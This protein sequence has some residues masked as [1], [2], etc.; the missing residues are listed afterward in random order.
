ML[1]VVYT[2]ESKYS[3]ELRVRNSIIYRQL[4]ILYLYF[5]VFKMLNSI[6]DWFELTKTEVLYYW[7]SHSLSFPVICAFGRMYVR[8]TRY[9]VWCSVKSTIIREEQVL[10]N[11][12]IKNK[13]SSWQSRLFHRSFV[14]LL[15]KVCFISRTRKCFHKVS[16]HL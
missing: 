12:I 14:N 6:R 10:Q 3:T 2:Y 15:S 13:F 9:T 11:E 5:F 16:G 1:K 7:I 4:P 8:Y